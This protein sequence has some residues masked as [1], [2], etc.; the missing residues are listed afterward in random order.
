MSEQTEYL[1][2]LTEQGM[3][4]RY[5]P[6]V[7]DINGVVIPR[8]REELRVIN[9]LGFPEYFL[10]LADIL[11]YCRANGIPVGPGRGSSGGSAVAF[12]TEIV[13]VEPLRHKLIFERFLNDER[14]AMPDIDV[15]V[16]W[17]NRQ[18]IIDYIVHKYG[19]ERTAQIITFNTLQP[20]A[21]TQDLGRVLRVPIKD[22]EELKA[23]MPEVGA[24]L[25]ELLLDEA[26]AKRLSKMTDKEPRLLP[27]MKKLVGLHRNESLHAGGIIIARD[28]IVSFMPTFRKGGKGRQASQYEMFEA[29]AVGA[30]KMDILGLKTVTMID[31]AEKDVRARLDPNFYTRGYREDDREAFDIINRGDTAGIFQLEGNGITRFATDMRVDS[32]N[33]IVA[34]LALYRPGPLDSGMAYSYIKRKNGEEAVSYP[35]ADLEYA[36]QDT[37]G[38]I[39]Y[40]EQVM[41]ILGAMAGYSMGKADTMRKA[42]GKKDDVLMESELAKFHTAAMATGR[43]DK[44]TVDHVQDLIRTFARYGFPKAHAVEYAYLTYWTAVIKAR[45]PAAFYAAWL[46]V[47]EDGSKQGWI[48]DQTARQGIKVLPPNVNKSAALFSM[49][50]HQTILFGLGAVKGM[51][52]SFVEKTIRA[53]EL[54][55]DFQSYAEYCYR[56]TSIPVDKKE[57]LVASGAFDTV[58]LGAHRAWLFH[59]ARPIN[60]LVKNK[61]YRPGE[62]IYGRLEPVA[63]YT[64]M[65]MAE[66]EKQ[67]INFY[68]TADPMVMIRDEL[69]MMGASIG[70]PVED[71]RGTPI[72]GGR[73]SRVHLHSTAKGNMAFV[74][75]DDGIVKNSV[76]VF[77]S[78]WARYSAFCKEDTP[79]FARCEL[80]PYK[81]K[82]GLSA[83]H[84]EPIDLNNRK[85]S[86]MIDLGK[87]PQPMKLA[88]LYAILTGANPGNSGVQLWLQN[89]QHRFR[90]KS[91]SIKVTATNEMIEAIRGIFGPDSV[92]LKPEA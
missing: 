23:L 82:P 77:A 58:D 40:Q 18:L 24:N 51:G 63:E 48:M 52:D 85:M 61:N 15:D 47:T 87:E 7:Y 25:D 35:H 26:F 60:D 36:L 39:T 64:P 8:L 31:W 28:P 5:D 84:I 78:L 89:G 14:K 54:N 76:T 83:L 55:G 46:N 65:Q 13:D 43:Y 27:A 57:A 73:I 74:E 22:V 2:Y 20:R 44:A 59:H 79:V 4:R 70:V 21:L 9:K 92:A 80:S 33:D 32:F 17:A 12:C 37:Y 66:L 34:L 38:I 45:Y 42:I 16:C 30:L 91:Q 50:D 72:I 3:Y 62:D 88:Q 69:T 90:L 41:H 86:L 81:G 75:I 29:E 53:R 71:L 56:L 1:A 68:V 49:L 10:I 11:K 6:N 67:Y 19:E